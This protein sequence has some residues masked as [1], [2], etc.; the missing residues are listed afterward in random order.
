MLCKL[1]GVG[2]SRRE[3]G[4]M[5]VRMAGVLME[6]WRCCHCHKRCT[7][8][9]QL[10]RGHGR[11]T[12]HSFFKLTQIFQINAASTLC[13]GLPVDISEEEEESLGSSKSSRI[14][15]MGERAQPSQMGLGAGL[16]GVGQGAGWPRRVP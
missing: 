11:V 6:G 5:R 14:R 3:S 10:P 7:V 15:L 1:S 16:G 9:L 4:A 2:E 12:A 13:S 8:T